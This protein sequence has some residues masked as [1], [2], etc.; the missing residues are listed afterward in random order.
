MQ[1]KLKGLIRIFL[2]SI[3]CISFLFSNL[4][5]AFADETADDPKSETIA[6]QQAL[7]IAT[8]EIPGWPQGPSIAA[9]SACLIEADSGVI[10]YDK[11]MDKVEFPASTTKVLTCLVALENSTLDEMVTF[12]KEAV[13]GIDRGSSNV[14]MD[15]GQKI[16]MEE[17]I[18]CI[19]LA[20]ANEVAA[21]VAEH[22]AGSVDAFCDM[23]NERAKELGC[24]NTHFANANG[25]PN[26][27]HYTT[28][29]DLALIAQAF[30]N[31]DTLVRI[32]GTRKYTVKA[33]ATQPDTFDMVNHHKMYPGQKYA[34]EY[35]SWGK[36]G[37]TIA[38]RQTLVTVAEK[39]GF[40]LICVVMRDETPYQ[41]TDT[42]DLLEY[43]FA[44]FK[45][46]FIADNETEY[47]I[48]SSDFFDTDSDIFGNSTPLLT[49]NS[50]GIV[51]IPKSSSF[52]NLD[53]AISYDD[54][55]P[56]K[57]NSIANI[58]YFFEDHYVGGTTVDI[59][60][61]VQTFE[62]GDPVSE[63]AIS[64]NS[65]ENDNSANTINENTDGVVFIS[66]RKIIFIS[67]IFIGCV[68]LFFAIFALIRYLK[69]SRHRRRRIKK[70]ARRYFSEF[71]DFDF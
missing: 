51:V 21:A 8:N 28:A 2:A 52:N 23:M 25:L 60:T 44:N 55:D 46:E 42:H 26:D 39:N 64:I 9:E 43:G 27:E 48:T 70:R 53:S 17:A 36:T 41:Y 13:F 50:G 24:T 54:L 31:N 45:K 59:Y 34:Y 11:N 15:V 69:N 29:H 40:N 1:R 62:F 61:D 49:L 12:S 20:S 14:G 58:R 68:I 57:P 38:A 71:D 10:L 35:I 4:I 7:P 22:V 66:V 3:L 37:F 16:T 47:N 32:A 63:N 56:A 18:Y 65:S 5:I 33:T 6:A 30:N 67:L 19:M